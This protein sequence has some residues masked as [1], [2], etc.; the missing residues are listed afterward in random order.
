MSGDT[1]QFCQRTNAWLQKKTGGRKGVQDNLDKQKRCKRLIIQITHYCRNDIKVV[2]VDLKLLLNDGVRD[3]FAAQQGN[4]WLR[5]I[6]PGDTL[7]LPP[8]RQMRGGNLFF[9]SLSF[10]LVG[11]GYVLQVI[12]RGNSFMIG[13]GKNKCVL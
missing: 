1:A 8:E 13:G 9:Q 12:A 10:F 6:I 4:H 3:Q 11:T 7:S 2:I 5:S